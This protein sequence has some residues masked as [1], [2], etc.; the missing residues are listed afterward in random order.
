MTELFD[1]QSTGPDDKLFYFHE[2][3]LESYCNSASFHISGD[4]ITPESLRKYANALE[5]F[6]ESQRKRIKSPQPG[7]SHI[8]SLENMLTSNDPKLV[9]QAA[10]HPDTSISALI[11]LSHQS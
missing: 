8:F 1:I 10:T 3:T 7:T 2:I 4:I 5:K 11:E 9:S 6:L